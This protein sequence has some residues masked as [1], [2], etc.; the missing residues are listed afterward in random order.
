MLNLPLVKAQRAR[1]AAPQFFRRDVY[2]S[3][4]V[5]R[6]RADSLKYTI[7]REIDPGDRRAASR[8]ALTPGSGQLKNNCFPSV[9]CEASS[10]NGKL[11][12]NKFTEL[13]TDF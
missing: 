12:V 5:G 7:D 1:R 6:V 10:G 8:N 2:K 13:E 11:I 9:N 4:F 3:R